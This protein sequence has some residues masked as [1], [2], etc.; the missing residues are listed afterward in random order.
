MNGQGLNIAAPPMTQ[1][2]A[3]YGVNVQNVSQVIWQPLYDYQVYPSAG[4]QQFTFFQAPLGQGGRTYE[5]T[6][7]ESAGQ[8]PNPKRMLVT[9]IEIGFISGAVT[10]SLAPTARPTATQISDLYAVADRG[11]LQ[12]FVGSKSLLDEAGLVNFP[13]GV[14]AYNEPA[15]ADSTTAAAEGLSVIDYATFVGRPYRI[16]PVE[17]IA[18][19]NFRITV[20]FPNGLVAMPSGEDGRICCR[21][22]G[23]Q[24]RLAQ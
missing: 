13:R 19:Q 20:N 7:M 23:Y 10:T 14:R 18:N 22:L 5:D 8:L 3:R 16:T 4:Q 12:F 1:E 17:L 6:N 9:G 21:L 2:L 15:L 24:Y 11:H